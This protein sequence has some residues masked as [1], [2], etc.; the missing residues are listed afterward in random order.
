M[1]SLKDVQEA[2]KRISGYVLHT[3]LLRVPA[4]DDVL[5]CQVYLKPENL[6]L[7][8]SFK[9]RGAT[10]RMMLLSEEEKRRGVVT[11]SSGNHAKAVAYAAKRM[12]V[13][14]TVIMPVDPNPA[15]LA[16]IRSYGAEVL[17][18]G[19][20]SGER[21]AKARQLV[22]EKGYTLVHSHAD[23][24][25]L[26]GQGTI[27]L[28]I[29]EDEP[30]MDVIVTPV[31]G[32][33]LISGVSTAAKGVKPSIRVYGAEPAYAPRYA[34]SLEAGEPLT[35]QTQKTIA[36]GTRCNHADAG[37]FEIIRQRVDGL[38]DATEERIL[39]A[40]GLCVTAAKLVAEPSSVMGIAAALDKKLP[41]GPADKVCFVLTGGN[42]DLTLL[43]K[44]IHRA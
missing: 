3:P 18:E 23:F 16:G 13:S 33:G 24:Y 9:V 40:M 44:A 21:V 27:A 39:E 34:K 43:E 36:D 14:A 17:F 10:S 35:I 30:G 8:G 12:G 22:E 41:V 6:Q 29:L 25:V 37:N 1:L 20:Q 15:K 31:G 42:N 38:V 28:E 2:R 19:T 11:A 26:A 5:G 4:L 7:T 32:G